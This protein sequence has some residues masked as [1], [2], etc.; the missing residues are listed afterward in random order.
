MG[1]VHLGLGGALGSSAFLFF[2]MVRGGARFLMREV[3][4]QFEPQL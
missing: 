1:G 4:L 3:L 2:V